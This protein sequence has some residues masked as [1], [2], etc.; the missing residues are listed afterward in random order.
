MVSFGKLSEDCVPN[1]ILHTSPR[2]ACTSSSISLRFKSAADSDATWEQF[3]PL[4][5][6][7]ILSGSVAPLVFSTK[8]ELYVRLSQSNLLVDGGKMV[9]VFTL[10]RNRSS[11]VKTNSSYLLFHY[12]V[13]E[14]TLQK[15]DM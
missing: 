13:I 7:Q 1:I 14:I 15:T 8:K 6:P 10:Y 9:L 3:F 12:K 4:D 11:S 5:Y 2:D